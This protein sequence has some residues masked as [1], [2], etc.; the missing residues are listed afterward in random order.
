MG[1]L[2]QPVHLKSFRVLDRSFRRLVDILF[3]QTKYAIKRAF[4][5]LEVAVPIVIEDASVHHLGKT[6]ELALFKIFDTVGVPLSSWLFADGPVFCFGTCHAEN[7]V[8]HLCL[9]D[10]EGIGVDYLVSEALEAGFF[11]RTSGLDWE[12]KKSGDGTTNLLDVSQVSDK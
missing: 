1:A 8:E 5:M 9:V 7:G 12:A 11:V 10:G 6:D 3:R 2:Q 4:A